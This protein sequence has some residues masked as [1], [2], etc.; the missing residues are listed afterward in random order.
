MA[1][2]TKGKLVLSLSEGI[3]IFCIYMIYNMMLCQF[4]KNALNV[5]ELHEREFFHIKYMSF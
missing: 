5:N 3:T 2:R 4:S 1:M